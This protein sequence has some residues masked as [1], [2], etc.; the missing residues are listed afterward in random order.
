MHAFRFRRGHR[1][2]AAILLAAGLAGVGVCAAQNA[3]A[4]AGVASAPVRF[5]VVADRE[6]PLSAVAGGRVSRIYVQ[7]GDAVRSGKVLASLDC[8]DQRAKRDAADAE[9]RAAQLRY[10]AKAKLQG[11]QSAAALE[12][13]LAAAEVNRTQSQVRIFDAALAQCRF[14]APFN[15]RVAHIHVK[16][17]QGVVPGAPIM[18]LVG[19]GTPRARLN[20]PSS[21]LGWLEPGS[22]LAA[23]VDETGASHTLRVSRISGRV[24][25]VSQTVE[26]EADFEGDTQKVLPGMSGRAWQ[27][28]PGAPG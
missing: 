26:I 14:V 8:D 22:R 25:A 28:K 20:V 15:G 13:E 12:V 7:L 9:H 4:G 17:G 10:E 2:V 27:A 3:P 23:T 1:A 18:D 19:T 16:E 5:L 6:S 24:D 21:W 11:L